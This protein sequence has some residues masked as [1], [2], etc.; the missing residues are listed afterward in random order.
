MIEFTGVHKAFGD[1][2]VRIEALRGLELRVP[3][4]QLCALMGPSGSGKSTVL[5]LAAGLTRPEKG[6]VRVGDHAISEL[7]D[8]AL[9]DIRRHEIG[10]VFQF[11]NLLPY[12]TAYENIALPLRLNGVQD[13][14]ECQRVADTLRLVGLT[15]RQDHKP[16]ELSGGEM[17]RVAIARALVISPS[18]ILA[19]E[20]TGNL[21]TTSGRQIMDLL[22]DINEETGVTMLIVTHDPVWG[23]SCDRI[24]RLVDG[25]IDEDVALASGQRAPATA[26]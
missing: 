9:T 7:D 25:R 14:E 16:N 24:L 4:G 19:D 5:H 17:Q 26:T 12:L 1:G 6:H 13:Q 22:Q 21:D 10:V 23:A 11:F 18:V 8:Q 15:E 3:A 20:P 2:A